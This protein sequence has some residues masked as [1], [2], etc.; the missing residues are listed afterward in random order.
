MF[1]FTEAPA[2]TTTETVDGIDASYEASLTE[3]FLDFVLDF[4]AHEMALPQN[5]AT[6]AE[7]MCVRKVTE[8]MNLL[9]EEKGSGEHFQIRISK[10]KS[11]AVNAESV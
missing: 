2:E 9:V 10:K 8:K 1:G 7:M 11:E 5:K 4:N 3:I 6:P